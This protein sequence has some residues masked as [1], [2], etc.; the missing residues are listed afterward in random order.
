MPEFMMV[1]NLSSSLELRV[2]TGTI[3]QVQDFK[4]LGSCLLNCSKDFEVRKA[5]AWKACTRLVKVWRSTC[6]SNAVKIKINRSCV[7]STLLYNAVTWTLTDTLSRKLARWLLHETTALC[8]E[9]WMQRWCHK[10]CFIQ[11]PWAC[12]HS[13]TGG[14]TSFWWSLHE[15]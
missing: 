15:K 8:L 10:Y 1:G 14:A 9:F 4:C 11:R 13:T 7:E 12:Q 5:L 2:S 6:I 3:Y